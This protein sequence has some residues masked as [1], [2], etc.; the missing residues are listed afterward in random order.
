[1]KSILFLPDA[2]EQM[3]QKVSKRI[4]PHLFLFCNY[5]PDQIKVFSSDAKFCQGVMNLYKLIVD[6]SIISMLPK[7]ARINKISFD[8]K[9][10]DEH[11][12]TISMLRTVLGH[13]VSI[14]NGTGDLQKQYDLWLK[15]VTGKTELKKEE[16]YEPAVK[17]L[18]QIG[19]DIFKILARFIDQ[20]AVCSRKENVTA[21]WEE[22]IFTFYTKRSG[23]KIFLGQMRDAY[24]SRCPTGGNYFQKHRLNLKLAHWFQC[25]YCQK[26]EAQ[27]DNLQKILT[28]YGK[29]LNKSVCINIQTEIEEGENELT[30]LKRDIALKLKVDSPNNLS[31]YHYQEYYCM[32]LDKKLKNILN[33]IKES[34]QGN[35]LPESLI[36][37]LIE[38]EFTDIHS[39]DF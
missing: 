34:G 30:I 27:I 19:I 29:N 37:K 15:Q 21:S 23:Q 9:R 12:R 35:M 5:Q 33:E 20:A 4:A 3:N 14:R 13:N 16:D 18:E 38:E 6:A 8:N 11:I 24:L 7:I 22:I 32:E 1:M 25:Y 28:V 17:A 26:K 31:F 36:Q 39:E 10:L 2:A